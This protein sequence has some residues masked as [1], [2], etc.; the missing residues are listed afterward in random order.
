MP[1]SSLPVAPL[2]L[3]SLPVSFNPSQMSDSEAVIKLSAE[4]DGTTL[5]WAYP[6]RQIP[7]S[8]CRLPTTMA[9]LTSGCG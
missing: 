8:K 5:C 4:L 1:S 2:G 7:T 3:L 9:L 6:V